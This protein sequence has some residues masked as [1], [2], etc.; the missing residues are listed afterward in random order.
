MLNKRSH[1]NL[2]NTLW[3]FCIVIFSPQSLAYDL[4]E[5]KESGVLRHIGVPYA[6]FVIQYPQN[7]KTVL[8][9]LDVELMQ[10][11]AE[12]LDVEYQFVEASWSNL[13]GKINGQNAIFVDKNIQL[14]SKEAIQGDVI[15][16]GYTILDWR[17][18]LV[19]FSEVYFPSAVW[20]VARTDSS[21]QPIKPSGSITTDIQTVKS[22]LLGRDVLAMKQSCLDPDLYNMAQTGANIILP[23]KARKLNEMV[24]A[25]L[26][27]DAE[28][29]LL[30]VPDTLIA[31]QKWSG[32]IK[33]IGP[34]SEE[35]RMAVAFRK[36]SPELRKAF[37]TYFKTTLV[38]G[39]YIKLVKKYYPD[40]F[41]FYP[42]FF[43]TLD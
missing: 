37:N 3:L 5:V 43:E 33:V 26:N 4:Q 13:I 31:L 25:I 36:N 8:T 24:P 18:Q 16:N 40:V 19:D 22:K 41:Y 35:Q 39:S 23:V 27:Q 32:E 20:L 14:G 10:G 15:S 12:Y 28:S 30:D 34:I 17:T 11:F 9:G 29:T 21:L 6:N 1:I 42:Q 7:E 38:N 2:L